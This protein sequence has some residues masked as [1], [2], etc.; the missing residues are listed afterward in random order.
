MSEPDQDARLRDHFAAAALTGLLVNANSD[1]DEETMDTPSDIAYTAYAMA[2]AMLRERAN[3]I[4]DAGKMVETPTNHDAAPAAKA[5]PSE[6]SVPLG[7]GHGT[8]DTQEPAA[9][10]VRTDHFQCGVAE[11]Y[12]TAVRWAEKAAGYIVPLY[13]QPQQGRDT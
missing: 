9:W 1:I 3:H 12:E 6:S 10:I 4:A 5:A 7:K 2:D 13:R 8:G 11:H